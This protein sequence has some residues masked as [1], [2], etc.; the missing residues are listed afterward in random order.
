MLRNAR[1]APCDAVP[2]DVW[3]N[4]GWGVLI[5]DIVAGSRM[6]ATRHSRRALG[7]SIHIARG[8]RPVTTAPPGT[9]TFSSWRERG[10]QELCRP[11]AAGG[12]ARRLTD[13]PATDAGPAFPPDGQRAPSCRSVTE[14]RQLC[15]SQMPTDGVRLGRGRHGASWRARLTR[16]RNQGRPRACAA[17]PAWVASRQRHASGR[18]TR[19]TSPA[20][21]S[22]CWAPYTGG[23][24]RVRFGIARRSARYRS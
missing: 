19:R 23:S 17:E 14:G 4:D 6:V 3:N 8:T 16:H 5:A 21:V 2:C 20:A 15:T 12:A 1:N 22:K 13:H 18:P 9:T 7:G 10:N 24:R 11:G